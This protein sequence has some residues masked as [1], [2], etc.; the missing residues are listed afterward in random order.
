MQAGRLEQA[1][2]ARPLEPRPFVRFGRAAK[3]THFDDGC[4][5]YVN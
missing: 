5:F 4:R 2:A 1:Q 3:V